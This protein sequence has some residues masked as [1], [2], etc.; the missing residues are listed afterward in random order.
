MRETDCLMSP[1]ATAAHCRLLPPAAATH[2]LPPC[3]A[4]SAGIAMGKSTVAQWLRELG[5]PV[6]DS[7]QARC[8]LCI[9]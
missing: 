4:G 8:S 7:D 2:R 5:V 1:P 6:L 3:V 9:P